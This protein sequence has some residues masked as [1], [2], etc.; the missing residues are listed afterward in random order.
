MVNNASNNFPINGF[1]YKI[2]LIGFMGSGKTH[3]GRIWASSAGIDFYD[4]DELIEEKEGRSISAIFE[5]SGEDHFRD[6]EA[7]L[8]RSFSEKENFLLAC[9]G[10]AP[11]FR[12][13]MPW[14]NEHG[15]TL[16]L[17]AS[18]RQIFEQVVH[19]MDKRPLLQDVKQEELLTFIEQK[20]KDREPFY[21]QARYKLQADSLNS[22]SLK[23]IDV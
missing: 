9:G 14:M 22:N 4:L 11:C 8:L 17:C 5:G 10:G 16:Y 7:S 13:N 20:L 3:W 12:D 23:T 1:G 2:F 21:E 6:I 15:T 18:P 19:E